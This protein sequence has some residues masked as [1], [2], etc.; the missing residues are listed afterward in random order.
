[1]SVWNDQIIVAGSNIIH[2]RQKYLKEIQ[3]LANEKHNHI[4]VGEEN[5]LIKYNSVVSGD[6]DCES[7]KSLLLRK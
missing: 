6:F 7:D 3:P 1:M 4:S 2:L 5:L